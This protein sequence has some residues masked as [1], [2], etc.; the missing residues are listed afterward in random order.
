M[1]G[2]KQGKQERLG[3]YAELL[4]DEGLSQAEVARRLGVPRSTV[5][6]DLVDLEEQGVQIEEDEE[7]KVRISRR[8]WR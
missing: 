1:F 4:G 7:G 3:Q 8:W 2:S 6:R 5:M